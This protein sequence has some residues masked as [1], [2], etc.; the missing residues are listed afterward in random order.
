MARFDDLVGLPGKAT[1]RLDPLQPDDL[2]LNVFELLTR[3]LGVLDGT[4]RFAK[5]DLVKAALQQDASFGRGSRMDILR[6]Q[7]LMHGILVDDRIRHIGAGR[8]SPA[9]LSPWFRQRP[10]VAQLV[11]HLTLQVYGVWKDWLCLP[12]PNLESI[13]IVI[14]D[15]AQHFGATLGVILESFP[16]AKLGALNIGWSSYRHGPIY[17]S[18]LV[19]LLSSLLGDLPGHYRHQLRIE[20]FGL[21]D[22]WSHP[23][24]ELQP[25]RF[26]SIQSLRLLGYSFAEPDIFDA[27]LDLFPNLASL[28]LRPRERA[29]G[30]IL[31]PA[32]TS[33]ERIF[34]E[35]TQWRRPY[36]LQAR[37]GVSR[38]SRMRIRSRKSL[39]PAFLHVLPSSI[40]CLELIW[41][42]DD[43]D[44]DALF[45]STLNSPDLLPSLR[46]VSIQRP[47]GASL[48]PSYPQTQQV[49][50]RRDVMLVGNAGEWD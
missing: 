18:E 29:D 21:F 6:A 31:L 2:I 5:L 15:P 42:D 19:S 9:E 8:S 43:K 28:Q 25:L 3:D 40:V 44:H 47:D 10:D 12:L 50:R 30:T 23:L 17:L 49:C 35:T 48:C 26:P 32:G 22:L 37:P 24:L 33:I 27:C 1:V 11:K 36:L 38:P 41:S 39:E 34:V 16:N 45:A 13:S 20:H 7:V 4:G 14:E 46:T